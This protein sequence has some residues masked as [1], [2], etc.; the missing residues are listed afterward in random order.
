M[1]QAFSNFFNDCVNC[2]LIEHLTLFFG[3]HDEHFLLGNNSYRMRIAM[4]ELNL[5]SSS[6]I[7]SAYNY[8]LISPFRCTK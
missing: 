7:Y 8:L 4:Q 5:L 1:K 3:K 2:N 6:N